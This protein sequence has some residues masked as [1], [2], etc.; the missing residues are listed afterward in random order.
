[1]QLLE[2]IGIDI[3]LLIAQIINF[4][5]LLFVLTKFLYKPIIDNIEK[6]E[7]MLDEAKNAKSQL[8]QQQEALTKERD[9]VLFKAKDQAQTIVKEAMD[10]SDQIRKKASKR[11][12]EELK[13]LMAQ[14]TSQMLVHEKTKQQHD[15][16][17]AQQQVLYNI[18]G[19]LQESID[20]S[21]KKDLQDMFFSQLIGVLDKTDF[22]LSQKSFPIKLEYSFAP[23]G[24]QLGEIK[25]ILAK[26]LDIPSPD[27]TTEENNE[28]L[29]G[30]K[31]EAAGILFAYSLRDT[32]TKAMQTSNE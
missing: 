30:V 31:L 10:M 9:E 28:L 25:E 3:H 12:D 7:K 14:V 15:I 1:M 5:I 8:A 22:D 4:C 24:E 17:H 13:R 27:I 11:V 26:K 19:I 20:E 16:R 18:T 29:C 32:L 6:D 21:R 2:H 23:T